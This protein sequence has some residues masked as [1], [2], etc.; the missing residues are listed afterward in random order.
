[1]KQRVVEELVNRTICREVTLITGVG[2]SILQRGFFSVQ[3]KETD[4]RRKRK[5]FLSDKGPPYD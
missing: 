5:I 2:G 3:E 1:M 4:I